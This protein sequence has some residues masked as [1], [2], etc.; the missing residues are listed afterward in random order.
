MNIILNTTLLGK[1]IVLCHGLNS[2]KDAPILAHLFD[3]LV[4]KRYS[5]LKIDF[6]GCGDS[7]GSTNYADYEVWYIHV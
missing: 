5:C 7:G 3:V 2:S 1:V 4:Q 6:R